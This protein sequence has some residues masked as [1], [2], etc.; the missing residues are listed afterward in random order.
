LSGSTVDLSNPETFTIL[1]DIPS[2]GDN[3]RRN[4]DL[5][6]GGVVY[7]VLDPEALNVSVDEAAFTLDL[8]TGN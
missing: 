3:Y 4:L 5:I 1:A 7:N 2:T 6:D 8:G